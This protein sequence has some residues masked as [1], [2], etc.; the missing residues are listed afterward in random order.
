[1]RHRVLDAYDLA[2]AGGGEERIVIVLTDGLPKDGH[3]DCTG[4]NYAEEA[5]HAV[6][7]ARED[8][9]AVIGLGVGSMVENYEHKMRTMFGANYTLTRSENLVEE[10]VEIYADELD[11]DRPSGY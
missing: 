7:M 5:G 9:V 8:D 11:Y 1:V 6:R 10:L 3:P 4:L 2:E